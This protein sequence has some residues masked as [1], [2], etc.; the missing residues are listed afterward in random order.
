M[1]LLLARK[2]DALGTTAHALARAIAQV[3]LMEAYASKVG[4]YGEVHARAHLIAPPLLA[5]I[6]IRC[7]DA[8]QEDTA[9]EIWAARVIAMRFHAE[10]IV[11]HGLQH[12]ME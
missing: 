8:H 9:Q 10:K 6:V 2:V 12:A 1:I 4:V 11:V 7:L 3:F 5:V